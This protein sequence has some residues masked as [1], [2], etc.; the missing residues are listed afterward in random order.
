MINLSTKKL[1]SLLIILL[2]FLWS[3]PASAQNQINILQADRIQGDTVEGE[4]VQKILGN[5]HLESD[6]FEM[7]SD[8]AYQFVEQNEIRAYGNIEIDT[9]DENIWADSLVYFNDVD[10][11]QLRG[12][13]IINADSTTIF[14]ESVDYRFSTKVANF[15]DGIRLEDPQGTL[16][17]DSG[18]YYR[19]PD[20][21]VFRGQVQLADS[22][23]YIEGDSLF[24]NRSKEYYELHGDIFADDEENNTLLK[25]D[26][27]EAD[28][29]GR[30]LVEGNAWLR[31]IDTDS[32]AT[33]TASADTTGLPPPSEHDTTSQTD[34][35]S[36]T[37]TDSTRKQSAPQPEIRSDTTHIRAKKIVAERRQTPLDTT[38]TVNAYKDVRI[39]S[40]RFSSVS[41]TAF[42]DD[43]EEIF[44][45]WSNAKAWYQDIQLT[46]PYIKVT[47]RDGNIDQ[48]TAYPEPFV[49]QEDTVIDRLN[50]IRGDSLNAYFEDGTMSLMQLNNNTE[51]LNFT[52][53]EQNEADGAIE[54]QAPES[55][56]YFENGELAEFKQNGE[57]EGDY[58]PENESLGDRQ[59]NGF[60][61]NPDERP[62]RPDEVME[63]RFPPI[64]DERPFVLPERFIQFLRLDK[65]E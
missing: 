52:K 41:D 60:S 21:A 30:R 27:L 51:V 50:Q 11:T 42:Y 59:L 17:A 3:V 13:V 31:N 23:Q 34:S 44:E 58:L 25:G 8:S 28:S 26:Y 18:F 15:T 32:A 38:A 49:V 36:Q 48:L 7:Y 12:R 14:G 46:G 56:F 61:W 33:D 10:F 5:V 40:T 1:F 65:P 54:S 45:I 22:L 43:R 57:I 2:S 64:P 55:I 24:T 20:S 6:D 63:P 4:K 9:P 53:N 47:L 16:K 39:W 29:T 35:L 62:R 37:P 19:E